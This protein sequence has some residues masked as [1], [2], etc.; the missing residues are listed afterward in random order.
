MER[1]HVAS[2]KHSTSRL[3]RERNSSTLPSMKN[4]ASAAEG[5]ESAINQM[6]KFLCCPSFCV[7]SAKTSTYTE[8]RRLAIRIDGIS[9]HHTLNDRLH[10]QKVYCVQHPLL[11]LFTN[12]VDYRFHTVR[13]TFLTVSSTAHI[14]FGL[15][16]PAPQRV[17]VRFIPCESVGD[18]SH[19]S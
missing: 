18:L 3:T 5:R 11:H 2:R 6:K 9:R 12:A 10:G 16:R 19:L 15:L 14:P 1:D 8:R 17:S 4:K 13:S 7:A